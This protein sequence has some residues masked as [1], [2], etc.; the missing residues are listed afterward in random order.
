MTRWTRRLLVGAIAIMVPALAGCEAGFDA[1][2]LQFHPA[3]TGN[4]IVT[5]G[6]TIDNAF[7]LGPAPGA[8]LPAGGQAGLFLSVE[9]ANGDTLTSIKAPGA[10]SSVQLGNGPITLS[11]NNLVKL[12]GPAPLLTLDGLTNP[13]S[14]GESITLNFQFANA[15]QVTLTVP[16]EPASYDFSSYSPAPTPTTSASLSVSLSKHKHKARKKSAT[17][18]PAASASPSTTP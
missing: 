17:A 13:L 15:G 6:I 9:A 8:T 18:G 1:P 12:G 2:T 5:G 3:S 11:P 7:V 10:A 4:N 16:V 14:G